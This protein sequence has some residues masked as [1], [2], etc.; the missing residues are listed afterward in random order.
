[1]ELASFIL[2]YLS[3]H[4]KKMNLTTE[5]ATCMDM[6]GWRR[7]LSLRNSVKKDC[8][9]IPQ[10]VSAL[11]KCTGEQ[12]KDNFKTTVKAQERQETGGKG[13]FS[14]MFSK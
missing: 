3:E 11:E 9:S 14:R 2:I 10:F 8:M 6:E 1:M 12:V 13:W 5:Q 7:C 4:D